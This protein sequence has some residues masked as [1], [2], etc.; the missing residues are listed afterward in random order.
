MEIGYDQSEAV[1][2]LLAQTG[3]TQIHTEKDLAGL[4]RVVCGVYNK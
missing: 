2:Q 3:F 4:D 1:E